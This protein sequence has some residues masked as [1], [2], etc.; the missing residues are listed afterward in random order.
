MPD[1]Q[2]ELQKYA[3]QTG[4]ELH[5]YA[6]QLHDSHIINRKEM[7]CYFNFP[8]SFKPLCFSSSLIIERRL[9]IRGWIYNRALQGVA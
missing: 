6:K 3:Q 9:R 5:N 1:V 7:M 8:V 4:S 2:N